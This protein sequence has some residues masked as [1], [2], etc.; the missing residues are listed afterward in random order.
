MLGHV[1]C[2][3]LWLP[4]GF[5]EKQLVSVASH[6]LWSGE[7]PPFAKQAGS[8]SVSQLRGHG[9]SLPC[10][11]TQLTIQLHLPAQ[12]HNRLGNLPYALRLEVESG[13]KPG[14]GKPHQ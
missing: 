7:P 14:P 8:H 1:P 10:V 5:E 3:S 6:F 11:A 9:Q 12:A 4:R 13:G 2:S